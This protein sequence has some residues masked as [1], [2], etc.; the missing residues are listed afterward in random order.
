MFLPPQ[1]VFYFLVGGAIDKV[2]FACNKLTPEGICK[3]F[4]E[5][6]IV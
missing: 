2:F 4:F 3:L 5:N 1:V 6:I